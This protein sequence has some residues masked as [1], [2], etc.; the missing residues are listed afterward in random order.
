MKFVI[1]R[2]I[3]S[4]IVVNNQ[5]IAQDQ[6]LGIL[7]LVGFGVNDTLEVI[8]SALEKIINLRIFSN[9][10]GRFD[11]SLLDVKGN[12]T[13]VSQFTLYADTNKGRR[14]EFFSAMK[15]DL[16]KEYFQKMVVIAKSKLGEEK[17]Q[18]GEFGADMKVTLVNDGPVTIILEF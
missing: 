5:T 15:P 17:V 8:D 9:D 1:Q 7:A 16:A 6:G 10:Q 13:L 18:S 14:P 11:Y 12:L 3:S 2:T 4:S